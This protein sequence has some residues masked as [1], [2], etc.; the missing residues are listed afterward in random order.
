MKEGKGSF[1]TPG[2]PI[3]HVRQSGICRHQGR[4]RA[5]NTIVGG[6]SNLQVLH[7]ITGLH[8]VSAHHTLSASSRRA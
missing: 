7:A 5:K 1:V 3:L 2:R 8:E 4:F 6:S